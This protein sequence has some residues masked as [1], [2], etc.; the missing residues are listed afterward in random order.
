VTPLPRPRVR[1]DDPGDGERGKGAVVPFYEVVG[2]T[3]QPKVNVTLTQL[4]DAPPGEKRGK[5]YFTNASDFWFAAD[6]DAE[7]LTFEMIPA[8]MVTD[9]ASVPRFMWGVVASYG[10]HTIPAMLHDRGCYVA[11]PLKGRRYRLRRHVDHRFRKNLAAFAHMGVVTRWMMWAAVRL[12]GVR[13]I[14]ALTVTAL[15]CGY[16]A[17]GIAIWS[18]PTIPWT[19]VHVRAGVLTLIA[20]VLACLLV[21]V[22]VVVSCEVQQA[23]D[24]PQGSRAFRWPAF[25][26][27]LGAVLLGSAIALPLIP[28][29][30][31]TVIT[32]MLISA[33][34]FAWW[35]GVNA[36]RAAV[37]AAVGEAGAQ[38]ALP[39]WVLV[40]GEQDGPPPFA[41]FPGP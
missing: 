18:A 7:V 12:F 21:V 19:S 11:D 36:V 29:I 41:F 27:M 40:T 35:H 28:L 9:L 14:A 24:P 1:V 33:V 34:N 6:Q 23:E 17:A 30:S 16:G 4:H 22:V 37:T 20:F 38:A 31:V 10:R 2:D 39:D 8:G 3:P 32:N 25:A 5:T 13:R 15:L 26:S